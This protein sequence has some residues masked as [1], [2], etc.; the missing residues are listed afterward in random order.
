MATGKRPVDGQVQEGFLW[1]WLLPIIGVFLPFVTGSVVS[2][3]GRSVHDALPDVIKNFSIR[4]MLVS[5]H[6][7]EPIETVAKMLKGVD[8]NNVVY[9]VKAIDPNRPNLGRKAPA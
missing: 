9:T 7:S 2:S 8:A 6:Y 4:K 3:G 1:R 5:P